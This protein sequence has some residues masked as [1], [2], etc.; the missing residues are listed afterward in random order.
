MLNS[1]EMDL[2]GQLKDEKIIHVAT[3]DELRLLHDGK[4]SM[5]YACSDDRVDHCCYMRHTVGIDIETTDPIR[6]YAGPADLAEGFAEY[7]ENFAIFTRK[8]IV[9]VIN[10]K[11]R[12]IAMLNFIWHWSCG[13]LK[14]CGHQMVDILTLSIQAEKFMRKELPVD[15]PINHF[16]HARKACK[17]CGA[18]EKNTYIFTPT[19]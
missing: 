11:I 15:F 8:R 5:N 9:R 1:C 2:L 16:F 3:R 4:I 18:E 7:E 6:F 12:D 19:G 14:D 17:N 13:L 10:D